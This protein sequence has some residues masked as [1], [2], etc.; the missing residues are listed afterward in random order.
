MPRAVCG[1]VPPSSA[2]VRGATVPR[3][4]RPTVAHGPVPAAAAAVLR[5]AISLHSLRS[6]G[7]RSNNSSDSGLFNG[8]GAGCGGGKGRHWPRIKGTGRAV[9][10]SVRRMPLMKN[11]GHGPSFARAVR[12]MPGD[13]P[14]HRQEGYQKQYLRLPAGSA[15]LAAVEA[16]TEVTQPFAAAA[17]AQTVVTTAGAAAAAPGGTD[18]V[19]ALTRGPAAADG[20]AMTAAVAGVGPAA[21]ACLTAAGPVAATGPAR[22][23]AAKAVAAK[24]VLRRPPD[25]IVKFS[26]G[27][28]GGD[29]LFFPHVEAMEGRQA[30]RLAAGRPQSSLEGTGV[31]HRHAVPRPRMLPTA[32]CA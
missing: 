16:A 15:R 28:A 8:G 3:R 1:C 27:A 11:R 2:F 19:R 13:E 32:K 17:A 9:S 4:A 7:G 21:R 29:S 10:A 5:A 14:L 18:A 31:F 26:G 30:P 25:V 6:C 24:T 12:Y 20:S 22:M 23:V